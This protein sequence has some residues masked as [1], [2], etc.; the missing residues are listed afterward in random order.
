MKPIY[1]SPWPLS[2]TKTPENLIPERYV[3]SIWPVFD[4]N[5]IKLPGLGIPTRTLDVTGTRVGVQDSV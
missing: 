1:E 5:T 2:Q 3:A 4:Q